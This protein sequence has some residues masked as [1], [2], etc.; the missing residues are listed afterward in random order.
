MTKELAMHRRYLAFAGAI[1]L[2]WWFVV[3]LILPGAFNP[4][5][6]RLFVV[7][8]IF[9]IF[10]LSYV[11]VWVQYRLQNLFICCAW[12]ITL[13]YY[14]LLYGNS[15]DINWVV[16]SYIT[17]IAINL[18]LLSSRALMLYSAFVIFLSLGLVFWLPS[19]RG[20]VFFPGILTILFQAYVGLHSR[21]RVI[22]NLAV[23]NDRFR[24]LFNSTFE[25]VLVQKGGRVVDVNDSLLRML[26][27]SRAELI[28]RDVL[29]IL[30]PDEKASS[31]EKMKLEEVSPFETVGLMK[32]GK[33][34]DIEVRAKS[35]VH[36]GS[37]ARLVTVQEISDRKKAE[38]QKV[39]S[40]VLAEN[41]RVR[42]EFISIASHELKTPLS[43]L[44]L[45]TQMMER[46]FKRDEL[47][48]YTPSKLKEVITLFNRQIDRLT[49]LVETMLDVS[50]IS[51][52]RL[53]LDRQKVDLS[54]LV[55]EV[56]A[57]LE[58]SNVNSASS[59]ELKLPEQLMIWAHSSRIEQVTEN[60]LTNA[61]KYGEGKRIRV[62]VVAE[63]SFARIVIQDQGLGIAPEFM[64]KIFDRFE[65]AISARNISGLGLGLYIARQI[66]EAH[67]GRI[68]VESKLGVG[69]TF[70]VRLPLGAA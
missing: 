29:D 24:L 60:L 18:C 4:L 61:I 35:F 6:S 9:I 43:S 1:Y 69:S 48:G 32:E 57:S 31:T 70:T 59:F 56:A 68:S 63:S 12:I 38:K 58:V 2:M 22:K 41:V 23:S 40:L 17:V 14:Y 16:G 34:V 5:L 36:E 51:A 19:L 64:D 46:D 7:A 55:R 44:K 66:V 52:G 15:G 49:E 8:L 50:R 28:G 10:A 54:Q 11:S 53:V 20:S 33:L 47:K 67:G 13:H 65:R 37:P 27:Y 25:G 45:Q 3:E 42:D 30:H 26:G 21:L 62:Q 39:A